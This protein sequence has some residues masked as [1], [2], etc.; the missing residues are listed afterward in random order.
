MDCAACAVS[1]Q[2]KLQKQVGVQAAQV[3]F[4]SKE[5]VVQY[6]RT[7]LSPDKIIAAIDETGFKV[8]R[9]AGCC[10]PAIDQTGSQ[11]EPAI[12]QKK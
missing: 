2:A 9:T 5:A 7:K 6:D 4:A 1:I 3:N 8:E 12:Q 10:E 11:A